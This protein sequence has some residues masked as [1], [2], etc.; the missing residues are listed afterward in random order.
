MNGVMAAAVMLFC[1]SSKAAAYLKYTR[2]DISKKCWETGVKLSGAVQYALYRFSIYEH[3][4]ILWTY[5]KYCT[6]KI[7]FAV[8]L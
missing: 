1:V 7:A 6:L 2:K 4:I 5:I 8:F 3:E